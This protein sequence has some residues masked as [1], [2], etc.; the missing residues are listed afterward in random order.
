MV[1]I[2]NRWLLS[3]IDR[4]CPLLRLRITKV[5]RTKANIDLLKTLYRAAHGK[6]FAAVKQRLWTAVEVR[7][8]SN[9]V[10]GVKKVPKTAATMRA[11]RAL[12]TK[13]MRQ[14]PGHRR[15]GVPRKYTRRVDRREGTL[16]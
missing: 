11:L 3:E 14:L 1:R 16:M 13:D 5:P 9:L 8:Y 15:L 2:L 4:Y 12:C 7:F 10:V 6:P